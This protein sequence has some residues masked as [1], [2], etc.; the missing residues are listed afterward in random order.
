VTAQA[1]QR[2]EFN[3]AGF[4]TVII[5][6]AQLKTAP[7]KW[8]ADVYGSKQAFAE[9]CATWHLMTVNFAQRC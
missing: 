7:I 9:N 4:E 5:L 6:N 3:C 8:L 2:A 1:K